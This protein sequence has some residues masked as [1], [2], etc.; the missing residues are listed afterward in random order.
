MA[1]FVLQTGEENTDSCT[2]EP[3]AIFNHVPQEYPALPRPIGQPGCLRHIT[4]TQIHRLDLLKQ[5]KI[6]H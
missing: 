4:I 6:T 3:F 5:Y 1:Y 2:D